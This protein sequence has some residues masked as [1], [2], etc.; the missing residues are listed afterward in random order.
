MNLVQKLWLVTFALLLASCGSPPKVGLTAAKGPVTVNWSSPRQ[1]ID[2]FGAASVFFASPISSSQADFFFTTSGIGLSIIRTQIVP[3]LADCQAYVTYAGLAA[4]Y[5]VTVSSGPT[6]TVG[7]LSSV[8]EAVARGV[9][10]VLASS[11]SPPA[12][13]KSN[14]LWYTGGNFLGT[15]AN[16]SSLASTFASFVGYAAS[17]GV[18]VTAISPQNEPDISRTYYPTALWSAQQFH[19]F[20]PYLYSAL[21]TAGHSST[22]ILFP[23]P[24][25]WAS[26]YEG[27]ADTTMT[28]AAVARDVG[29]LAMHAYGGGPAATTNYG[30]GQH[31]WETEVSGLT[32]YDGSMS[33]ALTWASSIHNYLTTANVN[34]WLWW[35]V[36]NQQPGEPGITNDNEGLTDINGNIAKR[37]YVIGN[38]S[39]FVRPGWH[40][41]DVTNSGSLL[42]TAFQSANNGQSAVVVV[43]SGST[44]NTQ[45]FG[46]GKQMGTSIIPWITSST[47]SL[48][49][50][51]PVAISGG[52]L[53]YTV[54]ANSVVTLVGQATNL[55]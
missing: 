49:Q 7:D 37:A 19:D 17:Q 41:V 39:K 34:A 18:P 43:N 33:D 2:G 45:V 46:V 16:Y 52:S 38:W 6:T 47:Q 40:R 10:N 14:S 55:R 44:D 27:Y 30:Y 22:K 36:T 32:T 11:W 26:N 29:I 35:E 3:D 9:T 20:I 51:S 48:V 24:S 5:C 31:V 1:T 42:V 25:G 15:T 4:N 21:G 12:S 23:E 8:Q 53:T 28:D 13:M 54:P 50:Q